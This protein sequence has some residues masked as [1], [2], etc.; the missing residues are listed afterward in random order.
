MGPA[1]YTAGQ[2]THAALGLEWEGAVNPDPERL[3]EYLRR[4]LDA[5]VTRADEMP[6]EVLK[7]V[8]AELEL[9]LDELKRA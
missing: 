7:K 2:V 6:P 1:V 9:A 5:V 3:L 8:R 4:V